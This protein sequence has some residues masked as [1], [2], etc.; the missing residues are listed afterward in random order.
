MG[1][2]YQEV[3]AHV[4][5][6]SSQPSRVLFFASTDPNAFALSVH[7]IQFRL[8]T[9][10]QYRGPWLAMPLSYLK[11]LS[12]LLLLQLN[13]LTHYP[14]AS[15]LLYSSAT[16]YYK[17]PTLLGQSSLHHTHTAL[18]ETRLILFFAK[19]DCFYLHF[20]L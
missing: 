2:K 3:F 12:A 9:L 6:T 16:D 5:R 11:Q 7:S 10:L 19:H 18:L 15:V 13:K 17:K 20:Y 1:L 8:H 14:L 4:T